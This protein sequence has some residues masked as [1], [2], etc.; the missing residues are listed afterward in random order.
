MTMN[1]DAVRK[2]LAKVKFPGYSRD[3]V[4]FGIVKSIALDGKSCTV[5]LG[6]S[7]GNPRVP[8]ELRRDCEKVLRDSGA[9]DRVTVDL[10]V[11]APRTAPSRPVQVPGIRHAI[12][13]ASGKG[14]VGKSTVAVN[15]ALA[16]A[17]MGARVGLLDCD[18]Y[19]PSIPLM[20]NIQGLSEVVDERF[21]PV[22]SYGVKVMSMGFLIDPDRPVIWR[23][24]MVGKVV[25]Q[26]IT[27]VNW[28]ELDFLVIDLP[29]G[30]GDAQLTLSQTL[31]LAGAVMVTTPQEVALADVRKAISMFQQV[32]VPILGIVENMSHFLCPSDQKRYDIFG[33]GGGE[34]EARRLK[35]PLLAQI[36]I[37]M[38]IREGGDEGKPILITAPDSTSAKAFLQAAKI[39]RK[40]LS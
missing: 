17:R 3:I 7:T 39:L 16:F 40:S 38:A 32:Q 2:L 20:M 24:P 37:E 13:V 8:G 23:G 1:E 28:G 15:L 6:V 35:V 31:P 29:P 10:N 21:D 25:Q 19:G 18:V 12:A 4:S 27:D 26:F 33:R 34:S 30:T 11:E 22:D 9:F 14:G 5:T 36:P